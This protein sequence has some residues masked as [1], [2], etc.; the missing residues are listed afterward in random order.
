MRLLLVSALA[1]LLLAGS[2]AAQQLSPTTVFILP[3]QAGTPLT[4]VQE[5]A[6]TRVQESLS[7]LRV[8][9]AEHAEGYVVF[10]DAT[11]SGER[12]ALT[13]IMG[14]ALPPE[15]IEAAS[16]AEVM[17]AGMSQEKRRTLPAEGKWLREEVSADFLRQFWMPLES[18][19]VIVSRS[20]L[21]AAVNTQMRTWYG[22]FL[23]GEA[24]PH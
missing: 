8:K 20:E 19:L 10:V 23:S 1:F 15:A 2:S 22:T 18:R 12:V 16:R 14:H 9:M 6:Y 17:Y 24:R 13:L 21:G 5:E 11:V 7:E 3:A 4:S